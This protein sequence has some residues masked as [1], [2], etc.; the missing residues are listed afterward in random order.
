MVK[1]LDIVNI[2]KSDLERFDELFNETI[3]KS[4]YSID[5]VLEYVGKN[6]GKRI[7]PILVYLS[8]RVFGE[9]NKK[10]DIAALLIE[11]IHTATL[12]HDDVI[13][14]ADLRRGEKTVNNK[15]N[16]KTAILSGDYMFAKA[17]NIA[18]ANKMYDLFDI[19]SPA[20]LDLSIGELEQMNKS[21]SFDIEEEDYFDIIYRKTASLIQAACHCGVISVN[22]QVEKID[23][24]KEYGKNIGLIFQIKD[25]VLD[26]FGSEKTGKLVGKDII[27]GNVTL[28]L[29]FAVKSLSNNKLIRLKKLW[30]NRSDKNAVS[31]IIEIVKSSSALELCN[32]K[33]NDLKQ[34]AL[35][36]L[37]SSIEKN[38][39]KDSLVYLVEYIIQRE[40]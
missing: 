25:D 20:I 16:N 32:I 34:K 11:I 3:R 14:E 15:W 27:E 36:C 1:Y 17:M 31:E 2:I 10:T 28:P 37:N 4:G 12:L 13:D 39:V 5:E 21:K 9:V 6:N 35:N 24:L 19:I 23:C 18:T 38:R 26:Y 30:L 40:N 33:M 29:I 7:R 8:A 22:H